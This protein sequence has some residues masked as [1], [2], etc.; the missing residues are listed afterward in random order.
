MG[1]IDIQ[2][3]PAGLPVCLRDVILKVARVQQCLGHAEEQP[4]SEKFQTQTLKAR[5]RWRRGVSDLRDDAKVIQEWA[6]RGEPRMA[7]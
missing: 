1:I 2:Q 4:G 3:V 5:I 6:R 7:C